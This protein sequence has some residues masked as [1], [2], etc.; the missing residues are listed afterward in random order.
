MRSA[1]IVTVSQF[2]RRGDL[3]IGSYNG[4]PA[5]PE[6]V[7][8]ALGEV[9]QKQPRRLALRLVVY[10]TGEHPA[11]ISPERTR[12]WRKCVQMQVGKGRFGQR[13]GIGC[14]AL[15]DDLLGVGSN[16]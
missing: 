7:P 2:V 1:P 16:A 15:E 13:D 9:I 3:G 6:L 8:L 11:E 10:I 14:W 12:I 4:R 5:N